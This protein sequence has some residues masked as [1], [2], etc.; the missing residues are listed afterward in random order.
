MIGGDMLEHPMAKG[1]FDT[2]DERRA[3][4]PQRKEVVIAQA[5]HMVQWDQPQRLAET[6]ET[7]F[8]PPPRPNNLHHFA[9]H[10]K[11]SQAKRQEP[12]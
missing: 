7:F 2:L 6:L 12:C 10:Q 4:F 8:R 5:G 11:N 3:C 1:V 9:V